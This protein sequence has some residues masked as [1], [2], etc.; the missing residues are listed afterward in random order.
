ML[1]VVNDPFRVYVR[2]R[3][4]SLMKHLNLGDCQFWPVY[5]EELQAF[6]EKKPENADQMQ[7]DS[8]GSIEGL[9]ER[10]T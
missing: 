2:E 4:A 1:A 8:K 10:V 7:T 5:R 6:F 3:Y 9:P